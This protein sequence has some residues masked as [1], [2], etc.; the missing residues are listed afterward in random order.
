MNKADILVLSLNVS[1]E[2]ERNDQVTITA[3]ETVTKSGAGDTTLGTLIS[4][5]ERFPGIGGVATKY[6]SKMEVTAG[7]TVVAGD[8]AK[9]GTPDGSTQR[10]IKFIPGT[11]DP[12]LNCGQFLTGGAVDETVSLLTY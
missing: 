10:F 2:C 11:D 5:P 8:Y 6:N 7:G 1:A 9:I 4:L 12:T 3:D